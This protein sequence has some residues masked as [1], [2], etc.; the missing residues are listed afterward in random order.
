MFKEKTMAEMQDEIRV[1]NMLVDFEIPRL[2]RLL[3]TE[4]LMEQEIICTTDINRMGRSLLK[5]E[6][7][8]Q[9]DRPQYDCKIVLDSKI[10]HELEGR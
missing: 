10:T 1:L 4:Q 7:L 5:K 3:N 8:L 9:W 6:N 2:L